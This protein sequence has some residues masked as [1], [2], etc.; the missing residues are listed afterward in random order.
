MCAA[1]GTKND[2]TPSRVLYFQRI[3]LGQVTSAANFFVGEVDRNFGNRAVSG[4]FKKATSAVDG[5]SDGPPVT[6]LPV[7]VPRL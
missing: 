6:C 4:D 1:Q 2:K 7:K 3:P 5:L